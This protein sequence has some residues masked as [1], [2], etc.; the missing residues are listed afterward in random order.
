VIYV[1]CAS[2]DAYH[3]SSS[4]SF[5][6]VNNKPAPTMSSPNSTVLAGRLAAARTRNALQLQ[7]SSSADASYKSEYKRFKTWVREHGVVDDGDRY[8]NRSNIDLYF[9]EHVAPTRAG[10]RNTI[11]RIVQALQW[12]SDKKEN[13]GAGFQV[14][15]GSV[16][17][18]IESNLERQKNSDNANPGADPHK[19]LKD[20]LP[21]SDR[22]TMMDYIY[23]N[24]TDWGPASV[25]FTWGNNA[26]VRGGS[27]RNLVFADMNL[28]NG[29]GPE[30]QGPMS[31]T[32]FLIMR[33]GGLHKDR[34]TADKQ[35]ACWRHRQYKLCSVFS[36]SMWALWNLSMERR[37]PFEFFHVDKKER[38][39]WWDRSLID[40]DHYSDAGSAMRQIYKAT[41]V[42]NCKVTHDR[43]TAIQYAGAMGLAPYQINSFTNHLLE[44][45]HRSYQSEADREVS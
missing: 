35:V 4:Q 26:A 5:E 8:I 25:S 33:K 34:F 3:G 32:L 12:Y 40:W 2:A 14:E 20:V 36:L 10:V 22:L 16:T 39:P 23:G 41:G 13:P 17:L 31:R 37:T 18:A 42:V 28:S 19:G 24:R 38:C 27:T 43:T 11:R 30:E 1:S 15:S 9:S 44:K 6:K 21:V 7:A 29:Y 45:I